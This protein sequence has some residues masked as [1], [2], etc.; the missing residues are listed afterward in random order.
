VTQV[1]IFEVPKQMART[2][3]AV[4]DERAPHT[5]KSGFPCAKLDGM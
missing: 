5:V 2:F 3:R 4:L 1:V